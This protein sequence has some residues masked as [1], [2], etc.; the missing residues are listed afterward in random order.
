MHVHPKIYPHAWAGAARWRFRVRG[1]RADVHSGPAR[2]SP[3]FATRHTLG[4]SAR[5]LRDWIRGSAE[6]N[7]FSYL[8]KAEET[9]RSIDGRWRVR[10]VVVRHPAKKPMGRDSAGDRAS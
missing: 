2:P 8:V 4:D 9:V 7:R 5:L 3:I 6:T 10:A 1:R